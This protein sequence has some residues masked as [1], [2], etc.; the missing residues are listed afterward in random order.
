MKQQVG[1]VTI[2]ERDEIQ[3]LFGR[4]T[5]LIELAKTLSNDDALYQKVISDL[6]ETSTQ[7]QQ[8][9]DKMYEKYLW[10]QVS[11]YSWQIDFNTC[12]IFIVKDK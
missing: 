3:S 10:E 2:S 1:K 4:K 7:F 6:G 8:W 12:E 5:G 9:W 11:G